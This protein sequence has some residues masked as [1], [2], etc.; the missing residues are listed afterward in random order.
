VKK[1]KLNLSPDMDLRSGNGTGAVGGPS[2]DHASVAK[3]RAQFKAEISSGIEFLLLKVP[4]IHQKIA[5]RVAAE[6]AIAWAEKQK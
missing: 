5:R 1:S 3:F 4:D 2:V 6:E